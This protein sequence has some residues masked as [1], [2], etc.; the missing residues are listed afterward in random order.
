M[1]APCKLVTSGCVLGPRGVSGTAFPKRREFGDG[2]GGEKAGQTTL[3][4]Y[5]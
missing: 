4:G 1:E 2:A 3:E 5:S